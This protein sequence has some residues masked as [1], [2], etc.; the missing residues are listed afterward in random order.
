[1][2][3]IKKD[4]KLFKIINLILIIFLP[5]ILFNYLYTG[6]KDFGL[7]ALNKDTTKKLKR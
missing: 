2:K 3:L 7:V 5:L 1:M 6:K 4:K